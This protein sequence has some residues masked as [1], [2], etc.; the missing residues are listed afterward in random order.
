[1]SL[2]RLVLPPL[3]PPRSRSGLHRTR[4]CIPL[5]R[6]IL[7]QARREA[8]WQRSHLMNHCANPAP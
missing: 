8:A 5:V 7:A 4:N 2:A 3:P 1:M 6:R